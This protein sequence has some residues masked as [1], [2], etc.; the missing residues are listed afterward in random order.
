[1][2]EAL[3]VIFVLVLVAFAFA[4]KGA[5]DVGPDD[6][7]GTASDSSDSSSVNSSGQGADDSNAASVTATSSGRSSDDDNDDEIEVE[8]EKECEREDGMRGRMECRIKE[9]MKLRGQNATNNS[10]RNFSMANVCKELNGTE[11]VSCMARYRIIN[12]CP[13]MP[14]LR[15]TEVCVRNQLRI[16]EN[17]REQSREC[18]DEGVNASE[19]REELKDKVD[20]LVL[21]RFEVLKE[22]A[23]RLQEK[24][25]NETLV[26]DFIADVDQKAA[27]YEAADTKDE[28]KQIVR[29]V[30]ALWREFVKTA[31]AQIRASNSA[32]GSSG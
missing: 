9:K 10:A 27:E 21:S 29:N 13:F 8:I 5:D 3:A 1:M 26:V 11:Q 7:R 15:A 18:D 20:T 24:G 25:A 14:T 22:R 28:K 19:C 12:K 4:E 6:S 16:S 30:A 17:I 2:K 23:A 31:V 32:S